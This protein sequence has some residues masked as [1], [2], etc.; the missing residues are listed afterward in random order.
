M[1][2]TCLARL[3]FLQ[4]IWGSIRY[5]VMK[6]LKLCRTCRRHTHPHTYSST[7]AKDKD[8]MV[9]DLLTVISATSAFSTV[10][11]QML[12]DNRWLS[13]T[14]TVR[15]QTHGPIRIYP[16]SPRCCLN[17]TGY[18]VK[19]HLTHTVYTPGT[20]FITI[21][22]RQLCIF[23]SAYIPRFGVGR[24]CN[25]K[26]CFFDFHRTDILWSTQANACLNLLNVAYAEWWLMSHSYV[27]IFCF[28]VLW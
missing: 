26:V 21:L 15:G 10:G 8:H 19:G 24:C 6:K 12:L 28:Y 11:Q 27:I 23:L 22:N 5:F 1:S 3:A 9:T 2:W 14:A 4:W 13:N 18:H 17:D 25:V 20:F 16:T 7:H